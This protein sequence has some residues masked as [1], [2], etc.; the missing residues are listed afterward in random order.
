MGD[1]V[2]QWPLWIGQRNGTSTPLSRMFS[3]NFW[4][5]MVYD[6][7]TLDYRMLDL[8]QASKDGRSRTGTILNAMDPDLSVLRAAGKKIIQYHGLADAVIPPQYSIA[9]YEAV[10]R[11]MRRDIRYFYRLFLAPGMEHCGGGPGATRISR[12]KLAVVSAVRSGRGRRAPPSAKTTCSRPG[13]LIR[14]RQ[15]IHSEI[16]WLSA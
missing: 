16:C 13:H 12:T 1:E 11:Y 14:L 9:Y 3:G 6:D 4:P 2:N 10:E 5:F 15:A 8:L 7:P